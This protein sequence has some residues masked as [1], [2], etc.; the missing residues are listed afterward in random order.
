[1][2]AAELKVRQIEF[3]DPGVFCLKMQ[4]VNPAGGADSRGAA[5]DDD[6]LLQAWRSCERIAREERLADISFSTDCDQTQT[7]HIA[8]IPSFRFVG[9]HDMN[10][11]Q[12]RPTA[13]KV[14]LQASCQ[15]CRAAEKRSLRLLFTI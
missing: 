4:V 10:G 8:S 6:R 15:L 5:A 13:R 2:L 12:Q 1:M 14:R 9:T 3:F 11:D 7:E